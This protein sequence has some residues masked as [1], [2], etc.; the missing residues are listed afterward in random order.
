MEPI[1]LSD[2]SQR[3]LTKASGLGG[4]LNLLGEWGLPTKK[5]ENYRYTNL[6]K[7]L[8]DDLNLAKGRPGLDSLSKIKAELPAGP[9]LVFINGEFQKNDSQLPDGLSIS[10]AKLTGESTDLFEELNMS[11]APCSYSLTVASGKKVEAANIIHVLNGDQNESILT[12]LVIN[13][14]PSSESSFLEI[15]LN[16]NEEKVQSFTLTKIN[17]EANAKL[18]HTKAVLA[19]LSHT[20]IGK[21]K[22][23]LARDAL[24]YSLTF[25][26]AGSVNRNNLEVNING[27]GAHATVNGLYTARGEQHQDNF[28]HIHHRAAHTTS[29]QIFKGIMDDNSRGA[30][31]GKVVIHRDAQQVDATQLNKNLLLSNKAHVDT[32]PQIEV[33]ADDV[34]CGHGAT[35]GQINQEEVFYLESRGIQKLK[36]QKILCH[37]FGQEVLDSCPEKATSKF[38]SAQLFKNFEQYA[39]EKLGSEES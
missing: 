19:H 22:A 30:F 13:A 29:E 37:A 26:A 32:R 9:C 11:L 6:E 31:T 33:Y 39:L 2:K 1:V 16:E 7:I 21:V 15:F 36:A 18:S 5:N 20:H 10:P 24:L 28:I 4:S 3:Y 25:C 8:A 23:D 35:V 38:L 17:C 27:V 34:K 14:E 12:S